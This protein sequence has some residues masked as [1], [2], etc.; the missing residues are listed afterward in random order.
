MRT[1][2]IFNLRA[3]GEGVAKASDIRGTGGHGLQGFEV[4]RCYS[5][6]VQRSWIKEFGRQGEVDGGFGDFK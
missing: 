4:D 2:E 6:L 3:A 1:F 5:R